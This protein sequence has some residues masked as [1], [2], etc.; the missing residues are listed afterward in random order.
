MVFFKVYK[1]GYNQWQSCKKTDKPVTMSTFITT[2]I[3]S[4]EGD[5]VEISDGKHQMQTQNSW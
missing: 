4:S 2:Y 5:Q 1:Y 3:R